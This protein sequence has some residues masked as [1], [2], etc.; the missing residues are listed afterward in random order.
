M[1]N[2]GSRA[3]VLV[4]ATLL[5]TTGLVRLTGQPLPERPGG[6]RPVQLSRPRISPLPESQ[7]ANEH[8][9]RIARFLPTGAPGNSFKTL[10]NVPELVDRTMTF[11]NY[12]T[13]DSGLSPRVRELLILRTAWLLGSDVIWRER[14]PFARK[15]DLTNEELRRIAV[16]PAATG[17]DPFE[18]NL[19]RVADQLFRN[20]FLNDAAFNAIAARYNTCNVMDVGMTVANFVSLALLYNNLGVQPDDAVASDRM[21][22]DIPY[23][24]DVPERE[25]VTLTAPRVAPG[26]GT[27]ANNPR[28]FGLCPK[29]AEARNGS[30][31]VNS[32]SML[33]KNGLERHR[34]LLILRMGWDS[35]SEYEW[36]E[37]VGRVGESR[38]MGLPI[39][40]IPMG[41][42]AA[43]W[44][45]FE[46]NL[47]RFVD[48]MYQ[49]SVVSDRTW[50]ALRQRYDDRM[51][52]D[53]TITAANYRMVSLALNM[54]GVQ[55]NPGEEKLPPVPERRAGR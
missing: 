31:Y 37:H 7:W 12:I 41:P 29:L 20:S 42:D 53:A 47:L 18:A 46:A 19:L 6:A 13:I 25:T 54:L 14:V 49:D 3:A 5:L 28:T 33:A 22:L 52:I 51:M 43:G 30:G 26:P 15:A 44:D 4:G 17:W 48:E 50:N 36:S 23:R 10:L 27:S 16:G 8:Q 39:E 35:Q 11:H 34:E 9:Q 21:P 32:V 24:I 55:S 2:V 1:R 38:K 40:R 45:P